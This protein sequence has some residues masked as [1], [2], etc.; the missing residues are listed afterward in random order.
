[1]LPV[2]PLSPTCSEV[3]QLRHRVAP[4]PTM[5]RVSCAISGP[6]LERQYLVLTWATNAVQSKDTGYNGD[7]TACHLQQRRSLATKAVAGTDKRLRRS[8]TDSL[9][10]PRV[11]LCRGDFP[12]CTA[13]S[14]A[15]T[16]CFVHLTPG[17][18]FLESEF[19]WYLADH[20]LCSVRVLTS[21]HACSAYGI[22][23]CLFDLKC[24]TLTLAP[25][26][27]GGQS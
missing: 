8:K 4:P 1:M 15:T 5:L 11:M 6:V 13:K 3:L 24:R 26:L 17:M 25:P 18:L 23:L 16:A 12:P 22:V 9:S 10:L 7:V 20:F 21:C 2:S 14:N 27:A 19:A